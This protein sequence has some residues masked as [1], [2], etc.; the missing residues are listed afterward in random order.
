MTITPHDTQL[1]FL[2][3]PADFLAF[4]PGALG[5]YPSESIVLI[6]LIEDAESEK[7][8][9][10]PVLRADI[11]NYDELCS[12][13]ES[14]PKPLRNT[15]GFLGAIISKEVDPLT[16]Q[17]AEAVNAL[18]HF[19]N[20]KGNPSVRG[21]KSI[22]ALWTMP[23]VVDSIYELVWGPETTE[24]G[25]K[26]GKI[27]PGAVLN[28][29]AMVNLH[30]IGTLPALS[31]AELRAH[32]DRDANAATNVGI[33]TGVALRLAVDALD[34]LKPEKRRLHVERAIQA[35]RDAPSKPLMHDGSPR[36]NLENAFSS[37]EGLTSLAV[38][39]TRTP[40]RDCIIDEALECPESAATALHAIACSY[41]GIIRANALTI[42]ALIAV[43]RGLHPLAHVALDRVHD[44]F[45]RHTLS[46]I[47]E[48]ILHSGEGQDLPD[49][50]REASVLA[51]EEA[52]SPREKL[53]AGR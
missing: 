27:T 22:I 35:L 48:E 31:K 30:A 42:W 34:R 45:P 53:T 3:S 8:T 21:S 44:E 39:L 49:I 14:D 16:D 5:F 2:D 36:P 6:G 26:I 28:S 11:D 29:P 51:R 15:L 33:S 52:F 13:L 46:I 9:V 32:F 1:Q 25:C 47:V 50:M 12:Y 37:I 17:G 7:I 43:S 10:G 24:P 38:V 20:A 18:A 40:L 23:D 41:D 19:E 4:I